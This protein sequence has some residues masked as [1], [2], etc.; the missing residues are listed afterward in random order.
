MMSNR[1]VPVNYQVLLHSEYFPYKDNK[2]LSIIK[3]YLL[4]KKCMIDESVPARKCHILFSMRVCADFK[5]HLGFDLVW[6]IF[7]VELIVCTISTK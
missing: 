1:N 7:R 4:L 3:N 5:Q 2:G 6:M